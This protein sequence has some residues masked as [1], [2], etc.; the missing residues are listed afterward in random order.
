MKIIILAEN[1]SPFALGIKAEH[2]FSVFIEKDGRLFLYDT[3]QF[4]LCVDN[5]RNLQCDL[6]K[7]ETIILSHGHIDHTGG[8]ATVLQA[9]GRKVTVTGHELIFEKKY[10][11][12][13]NNTEIFGRRD[14][15]IGIPFQREYLEKYLRARFNLRNDFTDI[16]PGIW[17]TGEVPFSNNF[18]K[19]P[20]AFC[21]ERNGLFV[22]D[23]F[24]DDNSLVIDTESGLVVILGC[25]HR[26]MVNILTYA[27]KILKKRIRAVI[28]GTHLH[29]ADIGQINAV[30]DFLRDFFKDEQTEL[31]APAHCT[32]FATIASLARDFK[33]I[34]KP[35]FCGTVFEFK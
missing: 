20:E 14:V 9:I 21:V 4:G 23:D 2:G 18:E 10:V 15:Y 8:L 16:A 22:K 6:T 25:A 24:A 33:E 30:T 3:G 29:D 27:K 17:L 12:R 5:A 19:I 13:D 31:F 7:I 35:A 11:V 34:T 1:Y 26:G 32:G 28:G